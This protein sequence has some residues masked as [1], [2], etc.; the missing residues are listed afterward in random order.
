VTDY[1]T[2]AQVAQLLNPINPVRVSSREGLSHLEAYDVRAHLNR[3]FGFGRWSA[4]LLDLTMLYESET[5]TKS[6]KSAYAVGY[7]ATLRLTICAPDGTVLAT[8]TEAATGDAVMPDFKRADAHDFALKTAESQALKRCATNLGDQFGLSLYAKG[9]KA[10]LVRGTLVMPA[11]SDAPEGAAVDHGIA[12]VE[13]EGDATPHEPDLQT[14]TPAAP[15]VEMAAA[16]PGDSSPEV[17][18]EALRARIIDTAAI[19]K[20]GDALREL[21]TL[22]IEAGR[23]RL[24]QQPTTD[25]AGQPTTIALLIDSATRRA[26]VRA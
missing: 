16:P 5:Q 26:S 4:D 25:P 2:T 10:A 15:E 7:R 17:A 14:S 1:L 8:Y 9:S 21:A 19:P 6:G 3:C 12:P 22:G 23:K 18:V 11:G 24:M 20:K 13:P